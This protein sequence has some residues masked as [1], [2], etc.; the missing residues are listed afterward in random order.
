MNDRVIKATEPSVRA[1]KKCGYCG[2]LRKL[3]NQPNCFVV[4]CFNAACEH[5]I[6]DVRGAY[7]YQLAYFLWNRRNM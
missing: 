4:L 5:S 3:E 7:S 2:C 6:P 1:C